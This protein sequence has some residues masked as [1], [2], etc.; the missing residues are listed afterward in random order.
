MED[1][2][3]KRRVRQGDA[4]SSFL[5]SL[6]MVNIYN[7][8]TKETECL[9]AAVQDDYYILGPTEHAA[10]AWEKFCSLC[11]STTGLKSIGA[12]HRSFFQL[13]R[14]GKG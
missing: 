4:L 6:S 8:T 11:K 12:S 9:F 10:T 2:V 14:K 3:L 13:D 5:F 7:D 1:T